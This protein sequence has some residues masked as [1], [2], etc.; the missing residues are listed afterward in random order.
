MGGVRDERFRAKVLPKARP[1]A[2]DCATVESSQ[3]RS[4]GAP[5]APPARVMGRS[6]SGDPEMDPTARR[7]TGCG[8]SAPA[9]VGAP[10]PIF[11]EAE[12]DR[13]SP[14]PTRPG[15]SHWL[16]DK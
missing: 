12:E 13:G 7:V 8:V 14:A 10:P 4:G 6:S 11:R 2:V 15:Q 5:R 1:G 3:G 9:P 16:F